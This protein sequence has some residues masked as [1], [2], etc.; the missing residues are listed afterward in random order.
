[1]TAA[2]T[3]GTAADVS[4]PAPAE[5]GRL[6]GGALGLPSV[7]FCI[8]TGAAPLAAMLFN[9]PVATLG[10]GIAVQHRMAYQGEY[11]IN[12]YGKDAAKRTPPVRKML[13]LDLPVGAG[14]DATRVASYNPWISLYWLTTGK[15]VGGLSMYG[16][17]NILSREQALRVYSEGSSW[18]SNESGK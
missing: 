2:P 7:L 16:N 4:P 17:D 5:P 12:R 15:T 11:F 6:A 18:F 8:V 10:G 3:A 1:M 14:T 9:V 13:E